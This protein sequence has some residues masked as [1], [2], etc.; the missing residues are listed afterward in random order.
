[1]AEYIVALRKKAL[2]SQFWICPKCCQVNV[3]FAKNINLV[4]CDYCQSEFKAFRAQDWRVSK[5]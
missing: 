3:I 2:S 5:Q 1:M 4:L